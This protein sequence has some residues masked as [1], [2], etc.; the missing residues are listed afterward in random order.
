[1]ARIRT[2][3]PEFWTD[4]RLV[5]CSPIA[6][7][8]AIASLNFADDNGNL[9]RSSRRLK[10]QV[11]PA[12]NIEVEPLIVELLDAEWFVEYEVEGKNY[13]RI[14]NFTKHQ[15]IDRPSKS[16]IPNDPQIRRALVEPSSNTRR[17]LVEPSSCSG[18]VVEGK[19]KERKGKEQDQK[20]GAETAPPSAKPPAAAP[21][22]A[23]ALP[24]WIDPKAWTD[25]LAH[26]RAIR[27]PAT[28]RAQELVVRE[29]DKLRT[30]GHQPRDV[31]EQS[32]RNGWQDVFPVRDKT[33][34]RPGFEKPL[35]IAEAIAKDQAERAERD[36]RRAVN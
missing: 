31:L 34:E 25:F 24:D 26:R 12:D 28:S 8:L 13:L 9:E 36:A 27:K 7:L 21:L 11:F 20:Q 35:S 14:R 4:E 16:T 32:I 3:K 15:R 5:E 1:M 10:M 2:I 30:Q 33:A 22:V 6:R 18:S 29:L 17:A 19:G 23:F